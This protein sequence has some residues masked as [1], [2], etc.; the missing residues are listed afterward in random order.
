M[1]YLYKPC[2]FKHKYELVTW[3][4][5]H[6]KKPKHNYTRLSKKQLFA[7]YFNTLYKN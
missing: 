6:F 2:P 4:K 7:I 5:D 3:A 1:S